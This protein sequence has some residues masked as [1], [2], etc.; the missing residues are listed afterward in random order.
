MVSASPASP[1]LVL[2]V[3]LSS[4]S[5]ALPTF[6]WPRLWTINTRISKRAVPEEGYY[7]PLANGGS[8][9]TVS[10]VSYLDNRMDSH[11]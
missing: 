3:L 8:M 10:A 9:L 2:L 4:P 1:A 11:I 7:S 5:F 6:R